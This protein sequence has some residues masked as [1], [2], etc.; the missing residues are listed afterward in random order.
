MA[1][2]RET[3]VEIEKDTDSVGEMKK[4]DQFIKLCSYYHLNICENEEKCGCCNLHL[5]L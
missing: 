1:E 4:F 2:Y 5:S 3:R